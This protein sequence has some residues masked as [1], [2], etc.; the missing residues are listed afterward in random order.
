M[1]LRRNLQDLECVGRKSYGYQACIVGYVEMLH[2]KCAMLTCIGAGATN[3]DGGIG[4]YYGGWLTNASVPGYGAPTP[5]SHMVVYDMKQNTLRNMSG[6]D[7]T[8]RAE[9]VL[10]YVPAGDNGMLV[11][12]GG[13]E[14]PGGNRTG[15]SYPALQC[16]SSY[17]NLPLDEYDCRLHLHA[18]PGYLLIGP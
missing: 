9:G 16:S 6:P 4:Y 5:L 2:S 17:A 14:F 11:Y 7:M 3:Q 8:P 1:V 10:L 12:F 15:V 18:C 13:L